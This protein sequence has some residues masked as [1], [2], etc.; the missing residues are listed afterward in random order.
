MKKERQEEKRMKKHAALLIS[1]F[2][3]VIILIFSIS[4]TMG[5]IKLHNEVRSYEVI[6]EQ[7]EQEELEE[8][9]SLESSV[10]DE[11]EEVV[12]SEDSLEEKI[13]KVNN[14]YTLLLEDNDIKYITRE[15]TNDNL[16]KDYLDF[17]GDDIFDFVATHDGNYENFKTNYEVLTL[18]NYLNGKF[19]SYMI[20]FTVEDES[21][22]DLLYS[23]IIVTIYD[24]EVPKT[25][26][27]KKLLSLYI[28]NYGLDTIYFDSTVK[29][30]VDQQ[31]QYSMYISDFT[32]NGF[33]TE[34][35]NP[36][37]K[38]KLGSDLEQITLLELDEIL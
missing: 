20:Q 31:L 18:K 2:F 27:Q 12:V 35:E 38:M 3:N 24:T 19:S 25:D 21:I 26:E 34:Y 23:D 33:N 15:I 36:L 14:I 9:K 37:E 4:I 29:I 16:I 8:N 13:E 5:T 7:E 1:I 10:I 32:Y 11:K 17:N 28:E 30:S 6:N 22:V